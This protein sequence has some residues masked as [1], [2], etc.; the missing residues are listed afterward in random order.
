MGA[1]ARYLRTQSSSQGPTGTSSD[2]EQESHQTN[3]SPRQQSS[4][5]ALLPSLS[6]IR[7]EGTPDSHPS[8]RRLGGGDPP[9]DEGGGAECV[10]EVFLGIELVDEKAPLVAQTP[11]S[12]PLHT[13]THTQGQDGHTGPTPK[14]T[15]AAE[16]RRWQPRA[17]SQGPEAKGQ[18]PKARS[19][20]VSS[21]TS[22]ISRQ[23]Y[24]HSGYL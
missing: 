11:A 19:P 18:K 20:L 5:L 4:R 8:T 12:P 3:K 6:S 17:S 2:S 10:D 1:G 7:V 16:S 22:L 9:W 13:H 21:L 23:H 15:F 24:A 14:Q